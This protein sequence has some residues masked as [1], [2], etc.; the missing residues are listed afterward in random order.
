MSKII[1]LPK[2]KPITCSCCGCVY[3]FESGDDLMVDYITDL[4]GK[5]VIIS[6]KLECPNCCF[7]NDIEFE[8][9]D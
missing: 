4:L 5:I 6:K 7:E 3:E 1:K 9:E 8:R 2:A